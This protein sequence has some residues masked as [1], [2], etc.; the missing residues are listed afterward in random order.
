MSLD[1]HIP[2]IQA[3]SKYKAVPKDRQLES[4]VWSLRLGCL[5]EHQLDVLLGNV[6]GLP[7]VLEYHPFQFVDFHAQ[8][9]I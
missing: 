8:T 7:S 3:P 9:C 4:D 1:A 5:G 2:H 6:L